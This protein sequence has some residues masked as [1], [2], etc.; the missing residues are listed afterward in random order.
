MIFSHTLKD[1]CLA[2][3]PQVIGRNNTLMN[4]SYGTLHNCHLKLVERDIGCIIFPLHATL[5][6]YLRRHALWCK[7]ACSS[8]ARTKYT[9]IFQ[10]WKVE[11]YGIGLDQT[12]GWSFDSRQ[13][14]WRLPSRN[15]PRRRLD[16]RCYKL[17]TQSSFIPLLSLKDIC[18]YL[19][20]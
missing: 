14:V 15:S 7:Q 13:N 10:V 1:D 19:L 9:Y 3:V 17:N 12:Y 4:R 20:N 18:S 6:L 16:Y 8:F 2:G 5:S 11:S